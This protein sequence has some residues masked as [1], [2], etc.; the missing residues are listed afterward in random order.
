MD[1]DSCTWQF[2]QTGMLI[3]ASDGGMPAAEKGTA[4]MTSEP[5]RARVERLLEIEFD[6]LQRI[7]DKYDGSRFSIKNWAVTTGGALVA[8]S[9]TAE[10]PGIASIGVVVVGV[11]A[12]IELLYIYLQDHVIARCNRVE[13]LLDM[14]SRDDGSARAEDYSFGI[15]QAF[16]G[17]FDVKGVVGAVKGRPHIYV[18]YLGLMTVLAVVALMLAFH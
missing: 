11:F 14:A 1:S 9:I 2:V 6:H 3:S 13:R 8:L 18:L 15:S 7:N 16:V 17:S 12:Y 10:S 5:G 4:R